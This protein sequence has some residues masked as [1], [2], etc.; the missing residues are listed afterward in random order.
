MPEDV[1]VAKEAK[2]YGRMQGITDTTEVGIRASKNICIFGVVFVTTL[3]Y[4]QLNLIG[5]QR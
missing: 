4:A 1:V 2:E 5:L 3:S